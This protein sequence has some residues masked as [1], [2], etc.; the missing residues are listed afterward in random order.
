M[1][2]LQFVYV[3]EMKPVVHG[4]WIEYPLC[5]GYVGAYSEDHIVCSNCKK[6]WS[7]IDNDTERFKHCPNCG[8]KMDGDAD[9]KA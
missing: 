9:G 6:V 5:L 2:K 8:A 4:R 1:D 3:S 7:I